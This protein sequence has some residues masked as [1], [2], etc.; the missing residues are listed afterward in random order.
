[1]STA[2][3]HSTA[4]LEGEVQLGEGCR[5]G[6]FCVLR[7]PITVGAGTHLMGNVYL[8]GPLTIGERNTIYPF[9]TLGFAPQDLK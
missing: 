4:I 7:G 8:Q 5:I 9:V 6:P 1:M 2:Q 3:V